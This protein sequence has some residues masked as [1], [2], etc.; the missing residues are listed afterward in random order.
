MNAH[1]NPTW[2]ARQTVSQI[3]TDQISRGDLTGKPGWIRMSIHPTMTDKEVLTLCDALI[4]LSQ[5]HPIWS[6]DYRYNP[7]NNEFTHI[8]FD[9]KR[10]EVV[11]SWF[12][13]A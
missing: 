5:K 9:D 7:Q 3:L 11:E 1:A 10:H 4:E 8:Y 12:E 6:Q 2:F 13:L